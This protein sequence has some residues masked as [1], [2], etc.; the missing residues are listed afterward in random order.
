MGEETRNVFVFETRDRI[1]CAGVRTALGG[2]EYKLRGLLGS[3]GGNAALF[4]AAAVGFE[5]CL[6]TAALALREFLAN[7]EHGVLEGDLRSAN[8]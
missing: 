7:D 6:A 1:M 4:Y 5:G 3:I 2:S 8:S